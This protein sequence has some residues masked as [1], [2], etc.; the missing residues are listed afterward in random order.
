MKT[1]GLAEKR[2]GWKERKEK[3]GRREEKAGWEKVVRWDEPGL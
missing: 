2:N 1:Q 3:R